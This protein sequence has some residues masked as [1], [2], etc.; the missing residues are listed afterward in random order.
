MFKNNKITAHLVVKNEDRWLWFTIKSVIDFVDYLYVIDTGSIDRTQKII[1]LFATDPR[2]QKKIRFEIFK[3]K[4]S[5]DMHI[6]RQYLLSVTKTD[7]VMLID[8]D[9]IFYKKSMEEIRSI[10]T[11]KYNYVISRFENCIGSVYLRQNFERGNYNLLG[12]KGNLTLKLFKLSNLNLTWAGNYEK[13]GEGLFHLETN[14]AI[15]PIENDSYLLDTPYLHTS[16]T[17]RSSLFLGDLLIKYRWKKYI[18]DF[19][20]KVTGNKINFPEVFYSIRPNMIRDPF[21]EYFADLI[22]RS[23]ARKIHYGYRK[24]KFLLSFFS[25]H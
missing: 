10:I 21:S 22:F 3:L 5:S 15:K 11:K 16:Y 20:F 13:E 6:V 25:R 24:I 4:S 8:G 7:W 14:E 19:D 1:N 9:E 17:K 23:V 12:H 18:E 2:Y